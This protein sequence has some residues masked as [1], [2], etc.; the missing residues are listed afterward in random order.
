MNHLFKYGI[1]LSLGM[2][3]G[4]SAVERTA[5]AQ[6]ADES[7]PPL[8]PAVF[9][10]QPDDSRPAGEND[11]SERNV[12][13]ESMAGAQYAADITLMTGIRPLFPLPEK[14]TDLN[15]WAPTPNPL[16]QSSPDALLGDPLEPLMR[17]IRNTEQ[18]T[19][20]NL[21]LTWNI[22]YTLLYQGATRTVTDPAT[23][24]DY[25]RNAGVGRLDLGFNWNI[26]DEPDVGHGQIGFLMRSG[27]V[28]GQPA[29]YRMQTAIGSQPIGSDSLYWGNQT[30]LCLLYWQQGFLDDRI[31]FT[32]GKIHPNQYIMLSR[33][34]NDESRQFIGGPFDGLNTLGGSLGNYAPGMALQVVPMDGLYINAVVLDAAGGPNLGF[35]TIGDGNWWAAAQLGVVPEFDLANG[36]KLTG[37]WA[38]CLAGTNYGIVPTANG[39][40]NGDANGLGFGVMIEQQITRDL[41]CMVQYGLSDAKLSPTEQTLNM[42]VS[43]LRPFDRKNDMAGIGLSWVKPSSIPTDSPREEVFM[44]MFYRIQLTNSIQLTPDFQVLLQPRN[45]SS[46]PVCVFGLRLRT[47]F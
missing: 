1:P 6:D 32:V 47:Q 23:G 18:W 27:V 30:S 37:N 34:A 20:D 15:P 9:P 2:I 26:F 16:N 12:L 43:C 45:G 35:D 22:Y 13:R 5:V 28:I 40:A 8:T 31:A 38:V 4:T 39:F 29:S 41:E 33:I 10:D 17:P 25:G 19:Q 24:S 44:E 14:T 36:Q 46:S 11:G 3:L 42:V 21:G 7:A